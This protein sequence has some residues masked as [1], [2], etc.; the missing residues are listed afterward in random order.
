MMAR[1]GLDLRLRFRGD[2]PAFALTRHD[3]RAYR[4]EE[5]P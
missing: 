5:T 3:T 1:S 2:T 4:D